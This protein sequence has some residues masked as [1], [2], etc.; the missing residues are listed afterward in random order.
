MLAVLLL[1]PY[2]KTKDKVIEKP[3]V[4][5]GYDNS[6]SILFGKDSAF[7]KSIFPV[8]WKNLI[9][10]LKGTYRVEPYT[11]G[12][13][14]NISDSP[15]NIE[16]ASDYSKFITHIKSQYAGMNLG[17]VVLAGDGIFNM[18]MEPVFSATGMSIPFYTIAL[19]DTNAMKD[20][21]VSDVRY[22]SLVY[23]DDIFPV[24]VSIQAYM[25]QGKQA[26]ILISSFG[27]QQIRQTIN[28]T[29]DDF[30]TSYTFKL[31]A[32]R[33]GKHHIKVD[34]LYKGEE[35]NKVNNHQSIFIEVINNAQKIL[36]LAH[37]PHPDIAAFNQTIQSFDQYETEIAYMEDINSIQ[38][39][40]YDLVILHQTP[41]TSRQST[42][43]QSE[44]EEFEIPT[45]YII[46][47]KS[48]LTSFNQQFDGIDILTSIG[49][50]EE[51]RAYVNTLFTGFTFEDKYILQLENLPPVITPL[52]NYKVSP[53]T[54]VFAYQ[55][56]N[57]ITTDFP[58]IAFYD[59]AS[60][61]R[62]GVITGEGF[63]MWR[64]HNY[65]NEG[66]FNA[67][68]QLIN[69]TIQYLVAKKDKRFFR[70]YSK[71]S[72]NQSE[73]VVLSAELYNATF[74]AVNEAEVSL[75]LT[76]ESGQQ[77]NY[78]FSPKGDIY[79]LD[80]K[81]LEVGIYK[82]VARTQYGKEEFEAKAEFIVS[83]QSFESR[84]LQ[85]DHHLLYRL[86]D[87]SNGE[88]LYPDEIEE[89]RV[90]LASNPLLKKRIYFE[91]KMS[92]LNTLPV[93]LAIILFLLCLEWFLRKYFGS[94]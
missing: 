39:E 77:F 3:I 28:I 75:R 76:D 19:G 72:Y 59:N 73:N 63:W 33:V 84:N 47:K 90:I 51:S 91:D 86:A 92:G 58:L 62:S 66:N 12:S 18:G 60:G 15:N 46:G 52:G 22:N 7:Y 88:L 11:F 83:G 79:S 78:L 14:I 50:Y 31:Q 30:S 45:L 13:D 69:K 10:E 82:Y 85:A 6:Q 94:Y 48:S 67:F 42:R 68:D 5:M 70:V 57:G 74:E 44:I 26:E 81:Q 17:A 80:L 25:M 61:V 4:V 32:K 27:N 20:L 56:I 40:K 35:L 16:L 49:K 89:L 2:L 9:S 34:L 41:A 71:N 54:E 43:L 65:L 64:I 1:S 38:I 23:K 29:S 37:S 36:M 53:N 24:E 8:Q 87:V 93:I 55:R 21:K